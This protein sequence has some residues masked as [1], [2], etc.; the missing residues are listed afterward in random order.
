M[1]EQRTNK[2][3][4]QKV[5]AAFGQAVKEFHKGDLEKAAEHLEGFIEK[6]PSEPEV[7]DRARMYLSIAR[8]RLKKETPSLRGFEDHC[9]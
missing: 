1:T 3:E 6:Y 9:H 8:K 5:L 2:D 4:Y 7:V